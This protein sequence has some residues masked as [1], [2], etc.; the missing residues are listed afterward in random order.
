MIEFLFFRITKKES[1]HPLLSRK[2]SL[3]AVVASP[4][5]KSVKVEPKEIISQYH[6]DRRKT[7]VISKENQPINSLETKRKTIDG[8]Q[9]LSQSSQPSNAS[10]NRRKT[11]SIT[12]RSKETFT[13]T[14]TNPKKEVSSLHTN[15][16]NHRRKSI[17]TSHP[18]QVD[19]KADKAKIEKRQT[20]HSFKTKVYVECED[21]QIKKPNERRKTIQFTTASS[22][23]TK[24]L[25]SPKPFTSELK[26]QSGVNEQNNSQTPWKNEKLSRRYDC[27]T[28]KI[29]SKEQ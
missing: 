5:Y 17:I 3:A 7:F 21:K 28:F 16:S 12:T 8:F 14:Q 22:I 2:R 25:T 29:I 15:C 26:N 6:F 27:V 13:S 18:K 19:L 1:C 20:I 10:C 24:K 4:S 23:S 11:I 9:G